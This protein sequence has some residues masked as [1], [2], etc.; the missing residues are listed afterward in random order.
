MSG[1]IFIR[2]FYKFLIINGIVEF[3]LPGYQSVLPRIS[4]LRLL[5]I[6]EY[7]FYLWFI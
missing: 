2:F 7:L 3:F 4:S 5:K 1:V 6:S